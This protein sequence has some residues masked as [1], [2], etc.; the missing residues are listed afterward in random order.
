MFYRPSIIITKNE[1]NRDKLQKEDFM[2]QEDYDFD[3]TFQSGEAIT[4]DY[5]PNK[6]NDVDNDDD[7]VKGHKDDL[8]HEKLQKSFSSDHRNYLTV[9]FNICVGN[10]R[11]FSVRHPV[12]EIGLF[13]GYEPVMED[14]YQVKLFK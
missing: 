9:T 1:T 13:M 12:L 5:V 7:V 8:L 6:L 4:I 10:I 3:E 11:L 14:L 2:Y